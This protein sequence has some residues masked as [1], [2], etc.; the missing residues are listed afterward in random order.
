MLQL[1][2]IRNF[3]IVDE[4]H[5]SFQEGFSVF[6]GETG[7]GKSILIDALSLALGARAEQG[8]IRQ[9]AERA[10]ITATFSLS[11]SV[12]AWLN[13]HDLD[14]DDEL[15]LR[16]TIGHNN[17]SRAF[18][19]GTPTPLNQLREL[20]GLLVD[21]HGQH[22]HQN[23][24]NTQTHAQLLD[25]QGQHQDVA[26]R[27]RDA[28][29]QWQRHLRSL[30]QAQSEQDRAREQLEQLQWQI[31][32]L[33]TLDLAE[34]E[35]DQLI[36]EQQ[37][38]AHAHTLLDRLSL[39]LHLL[40]GDSS[41]GDTTHSAQ[42]ALFQAEQHVQEVL[43]HDER[44]QNVSQSLTSAH[45][46]CTEAISDLNSYISNIEIDPARLEDVD[47]RMAQ[48]F[49]LSRR[50]HCEPNELPAKYQSLCEE[51]DQLEQSL[52]I[53]TLEKQCQAAEQAFMQQAE[54]LSA[55][56]QETATWLSEQVT[57]SMQE[58]AM[59]GGRFEVRLT[60]C[61]AQASGLEQVE[62][63]VAGHAGSH[64]APLARVAS[65]G[66][67]ARISLALS[68]IASRATR[69]P[70][71]I[72]DEVD[73]GI[74]GA[75]AEVVGRL[76]AQLGKRHQ[77]LCVTHLAQVAA[78]AGH[79][80]QVSKTTQNE[81]TTSA[82]TALDESQRIDE[83]ARMLGGIKITPTTREHAREMLGQ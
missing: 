59:Q 33:E 72:F 67:L 28:W 29:R 53:E 82:I 60:P 47:A 57:Q 51:R 30:E 8:F 74:G 12:Q 6:S 39:A 27:T 55:A 79:H 26:A 5:I 65:G 61:P 69:V 3:V 32:Q 48:A 16:R 63:L 9:G 76:L 35:W 25:E 1:L 78:R 23:L 42:N 52:D 40:E 10:E 2:H 36:Q 24:L 80:F 46:A 77:V 68:V 50:F 11:P 18:I 19:N 54:Q 41:S 64:P 49:D 31:E 37:R 21:I 73:T 14:V 75:V 70:T 62:F 56:R 34:N 15:I 22:A 66:E 71:L 45:I 20:T 58:L 81:H 44:L 38:L 17:R 13:E 43:P 4:A 83:L 7:A